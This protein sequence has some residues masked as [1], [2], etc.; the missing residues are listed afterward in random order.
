M[1][2]CSS[3]TGAGMSGKTQGCIKIIQA[4]YEF[5]QIFVLNLIHYIE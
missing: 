3:I 1:F 5:V 4:D 2:F